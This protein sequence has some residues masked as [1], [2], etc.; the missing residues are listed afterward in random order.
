VAF[1]H[2]AP[3]QLDA[4]RAAAVALGFNSDGNLE[5]LAKEINPAFVGGVMVGPSPNAKLLSMTAALN[6][7]RILVSGQVPF[8]IWLENAAFLAGGQP[9]ELV[10]RDA[11]AAIS[12]DGT[13]SGAQPM[14][15]EAT[16]RRQGGALE[17][18]ILEDDTLGVEFL[19]QGAATASSVAKLMVHR[20]FAGAPSFVAGG[21]PDWGLG[22]GWMIGPRLVLTNHHV[23]A[24]RQS[25]EAPP[26]DQDFDLQGRNMD[27][28][29]DLFDANANGVTTRAVACVLTDKTLD[30]AVLRLDQTAPE[31]RPLRLRKNALTRLPGSALRDRVNVLQHPMGKPMRLGFRNNFVVTGAT[32]HLS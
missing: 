29:F 22:T 3:A 2:L 9:E 24:A 14:D 30:Y 16:P 19:L 8:A 28:I 7:T 23:V 12:A 4:V 10:F 25:G 15:V 18:L 13:P 5:A 32:D 6:E 31:R 17:I 27:V 21:E 26:S 11:L 1:A 20:H